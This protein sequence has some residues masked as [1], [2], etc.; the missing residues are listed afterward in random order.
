LD[1]NL[2]KKTA[3]AA[4]GMTP[5][6]PLPAFPRIS[7]ALLATAPKETFF[8]FAYIMRRANAKVKHYFSQ[9]IL[10]RIR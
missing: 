6:L 3:K 1:G 7:D 5:A 8:E 9:M 4:S 2:E 10:F